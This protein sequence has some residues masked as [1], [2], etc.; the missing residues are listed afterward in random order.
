MKQHGQQASAG[1]NLRLQR[2][3]SSVRSHHGGMSHQN[4]D[5]AQGL[6]HCMLYLGTFRPF[7]GFQAKILCHLV[8]KYSQ[9]AA[10]SGG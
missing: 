2:A 6:S 1:G 8:I 4:N 10:V 5:S 7:C 9:C 3:G